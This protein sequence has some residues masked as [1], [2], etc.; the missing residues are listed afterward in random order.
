M[1]YPLHREI[2]Y[3]GRAIPHKHKGKIYHLYSIGYTKSVLLFPRLH[4]VED[5]SSRLKK[6][7]PSPRYKVTSGIDNMRIK[8]WL[9]YHIG[10]SVWEDVSS[11]WLVW[12]ISPK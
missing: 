11:V 5:L 7:Y 1:G 6:E 8:A 12:K 10:K 4:H 9:I 3:T 2:K